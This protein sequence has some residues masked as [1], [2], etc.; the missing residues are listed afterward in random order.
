M[1]NQN[2][3]IMKFYTSIL[4]T[5]IFSSSLSAQVVDKA[6]DK[7][8][9]K[10]NQRIDKKIDNSIDDGLDAIEGL[11]KKKQSKSDDTESEERSPRSEEP[12]MSPFMNMMGNKKIEKTFDFNQLITLE[13][14]MVEKNGK[15]DEQYTSL[16]YL[17]DTHPNIGMNMGQGIEGAESMDMMIFDIAEKQMLMMM[18]NNGQKMGFVMDTEEITES[19]DDSDVA[20]MKITKTGNSK[21]ISGYDCDEYVFEGAEFEEGEK[22]TAWITQDAEV[23]WIDAWS[24]AMTANKKAEMKQ[25]LP[26]NYPNGA[27]IQTIYE[28]KSGKQYVM[29]VTSI[30][31]DHRESIDTKGYNFMSMPAG[32][33]MPMGN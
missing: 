13:T 29:T 2:T 30:D 12:E 3:S 14:R 5:F 24:E 10:T 31:T 9:R 20:D 19:A 16:V 22:Q 11:F 7:A 33:S 15:S 6:E 8:K 26:E 28:E 18:T 27:V 4:L 25:K 17:S 21:T 32:K 1:I 23:N